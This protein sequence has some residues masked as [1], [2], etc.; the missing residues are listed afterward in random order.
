MTAPAG[1]VATAAFDDARRVLAGL[2]TD[3]PAA[4]PPL[5]LTGR[6]LTVHAT[7][8]VQP[9]PVV[10][11]SG[12]EPPAPRQPTTPRR[13][14]MPVRLAPGRPGLAEVAAAIVRGTVTSRLLVEEAL[15][16][17]ARTA[18]LGGVVHLDAEE[19]RRQADILDAEAAAGRIRGP[20][21]GVPVTV[22][23]V[24]HVDGMPT[25]AGSAAYENLQPV[26]GT[27][28]ARLRSAGAL[29]LAKVATHEFALGV[30][31]PQCRNPHDPSVI[32]GGSSGGS[33]IAVATGVGL[34]SLGTDTRASLRVPSALCGV[35]GFK[36][37]LG[38][39]PTDGIVPLSW[40][41]DH[42]GPIA[43]TVGD[44]ALVLDVLAG[45]AGI[46]GLRWAA[47]LDDRRPV[48]GVVP[49]VLAAADPA[50]ADA[51]DGALHALAGLG[52]PVVALDGPGPAD[53]EVG[54]ALGLLISRAE[55]TTFHRSQGTDL[56][57][58]IPEVRDQLRVALGITAA[59]YLDAQRQRR[60]LAE[61]TLAHFA[62]VDI[63]VSPTTPVP[64]PPADD[65]EEYLLVLSRNAIIWSLVGNPV[66]SLPCGTTPSGLPVG[67]QL[68]GP[69]GGEALLAATGS[70]LESAL[71]GPR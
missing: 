31:T 51:V 33:A 21:H 47:G 26:E 49:D 62:K 39:V 65:Y 55:A 19:A 69:P 13:P 56:D 46:G 1:T 8:V 4:P 44:A 23:D 40:T 58:C 63:L 61:R 52:C 66:L 28:V 68:T 14:A 11:R 5:L 2:P 50:V 35:V 70:L 41:M 18:E 12:G 15:E 30:T 7:P 64:A 54:N 22:K 16:V 57:R 24:I 20:L 10:P 45:Q 9:P 25:R 60:T 67:V 27:A 29:L 53:L 3:D 42:L 36:P 17:A 37:T 38:R 32:A 71:A 43:R 48:V 34:A 59:D 6:H